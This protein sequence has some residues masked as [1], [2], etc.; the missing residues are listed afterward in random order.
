MREEVIIVGLHGKHLK[1]LE[2]VSRL[3]AVD[4][5]LSWDC[6]EGLL[7]SEDSYVAGVD[8]KLPG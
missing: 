4:G 7:Y 3:G 6:Q 1:I 8:D 2:K 5:M